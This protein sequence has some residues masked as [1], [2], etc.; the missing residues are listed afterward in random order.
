MAWRRLGVR[1]IMRD[2]SS[3]LLSSPLLSSYSRSSVGVAQWIARLGVKR[4]A[5]IVFVVVVVF[6]FVV[7][8]VVVVVFTWVGVEAR[9]GARSVHGVALGV[10]A[11][12]IWVQ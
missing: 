7:V 2:L 10:E 11:W 12:S 4:S 5:E 3:P 1:K 9:R 8:V 6:S